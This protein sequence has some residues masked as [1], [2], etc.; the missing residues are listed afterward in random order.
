MPNPQQSDPT[1]QPHPRGVEPNPNYTNI[2]MWSYI[3]P[4]DRARIFPLSEL[5]HCNA[6][7]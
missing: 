1:A 3:R 4:H 6:S 5:L 2:D 7:S